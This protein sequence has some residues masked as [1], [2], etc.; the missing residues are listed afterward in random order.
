MAIPR[1]LK[2]FLALSR[3][4]HGLIDM[5][6]PCFAAL[7]W[8]GRFPSAGV[9]L[10]GL[11]TV[12]AGYTAVYALNDV[13]GFRSDRAKIRAGALP[14]KAGGDLDAMMVRHPMAQ[15][16][17]SFAAG[18]VWAFGWSAV[19]VAGAYVLNPVCVLI[20]LA[21]C[22]LEAVYCLLWRVSPYR[23]LVSG[24]VKTA[25]A[26]A[27]VFAV[28]PS[29]SAAYVAVLFFVIF[30]WEIGGQNAPNDWTD[31]E[32]DRRFGGKTIPVMMGLDKTRDVILGSLFLAVAL[33]L[34][35]LS[36]SRT[37]IA[38]WA[39][40]IAAAAGA[41]LLLVP[42]WKLHG[43]LKAADAMRLFNRASYYPMALLGVTLLAIVF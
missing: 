17:L 26:V 35:L 40:I 28:D 34:L 24:A 43:S 23:S 21:G 37:A 25:G 1:K 11:V 19:A 39:Y 13:I 31:I 30:F 18:A 6:A 22:A 5:A 10:I 15:G 32:E 12:F 38:P 9:V 16:D 2:S 8:L 14:A 41:Y 4:P 3:T 36:L 42:A 33:S 29:P 27:A 7:L 20:F